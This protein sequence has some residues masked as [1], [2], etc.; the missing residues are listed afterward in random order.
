MPVQHLFHLGGI[1]ILTPADDH[2]L[3]A[4]HNINKSFLIYTHQVAAVE[5]PVHNGF[6]GSPGVSI[7]L[8]HHAGA[9]VDNLSHLAHR[10]IVAFA[11]HCSDLNSHDGF[12]NRGRLTQ[13]IRRL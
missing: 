1:Y 6:P 12:S 8:Q 7:I 5:P 13:G 9:A 11:I 3:L 4:V 10:N 2:V